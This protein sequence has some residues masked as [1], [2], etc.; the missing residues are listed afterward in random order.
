MESYEMFKKLTG[1]Q[2]KGNIPPPKKLTDLNS[3]YMKYKVHTN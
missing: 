1:G 2:E 3:N